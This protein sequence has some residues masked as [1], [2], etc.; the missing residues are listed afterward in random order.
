MII[1]FLNF[2]RLDYYV[3]QPGDIRALEGVVTVEDGYESDGEMH[4][5]TVRGGQATLY[6]TCGP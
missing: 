5:V 6:T 1:L 4:L 2:Y 3:Y